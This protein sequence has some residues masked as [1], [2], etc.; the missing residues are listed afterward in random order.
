MS[1][2][3]ES[4]SHQ[5]DPTEG[6]QKHNVMQDDFGWQVPVEAVPVPSEGK[7]YSPD[8]SM[9]GRHSLEIKAMTAQEEDILTSRALIQ[10]GTVIKALLE[11]CLLDKTVDVDE[12]LLGDKNALMVSVRITG[13]GSSYGATVSCPECVR[14]SSQDFDLSSMEIKRLEIESVTPGE[15]RFE[16]RLPVTG[17][18]V[19]FKF[20][21]G[22]DDDEITTT[23]DRRRKM[24]DSGV[25]SMVT[26]RLSHQ[27]IAVD[28]VT[29]KNKLSAFVRSMPA[30]DSRKLRNYISEHEPGVDM[31][32]WMS[33]THCSADSRVSLPLGSNFFW[34]AG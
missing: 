33:C 4:A 6:I 20:L 23:A 2:Q 22:Y 16:F 30:Q 12:L 21:T 10:Q 28:N 9:Y 34:P 31:R 13:Y 8:S 17:K 7:V 18:L 24:M 26:T 15:N 11:S 32:V 27:I 5:A 25:E 14:S 3:Q 29:D 19:H 1:D